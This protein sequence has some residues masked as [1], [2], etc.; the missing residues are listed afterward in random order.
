MDKAHHS[1]VNT[2]DIKKL[3]M[4]WYGMVPYHTTIFFCLLFLV[5]EI[6]YH[7]TIPQRT[8]MRSTTPNYTKSW[9][10]RLHDNHERLKNYVHNGM[11]VPLPKWGQR[12]MG[13]IY[14]LTPIVGGYYVMQWAIGK[15][16]QSIGP[17]GEY[18]PASVKESTASTPQ[19]KYGVHLATS[20]EAT[21]QRNRK[22]LERF[23]KK[24][25]Q[26]SS[27][28][29]TTTTKESQQASSEASTER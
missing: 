29:T 9:F 14:F 11:R 19:P 27:S 22:K 8:T 6:P 4:A 20:D 1:L 18:L 26:S 15:A 23:L 17:Q 12:C 21:R 10:Q 5:K 24:Q 2:V 28:N 16:H 25:L 7:H 3:F 13:F